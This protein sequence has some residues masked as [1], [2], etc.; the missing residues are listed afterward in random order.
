MYVGSVGDLSW[1]R[2]E[3][4]VGREK[5]GETKRQAEAHELSQLSQ[6]SH[7]Y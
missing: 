3:A 4:S 7:S 1:V 5:G 2:L 6:L